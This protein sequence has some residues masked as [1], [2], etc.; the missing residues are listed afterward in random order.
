MWGLVHRSWS[1]RTARSWATPCASCP[2]SARCAWP[3]HRLIL[4]AARNTVFADLLAPA[5]A[6]VF[7]EVLSPTTLG[8]EPARLAAHLRGL[9]P[10]SAVLDTRSN[11]KAVNSWLAA[12]AVGA[13]I[14]SAN[15]GRH[16]LRRGISGFYQRRPAANSERVH[17]MVELGHL[18]ASHGARLVTVSA[19]PNFP[20]WLPA[21]P[22]WRSLRAEDLGGE[23]MG[24]IPAEAALAAVAELLEGLG[25]DELRADRA[26]PAD[27]RKLGAE[28]ERA[29]PRAA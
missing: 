3:G 21:T 29:S 2:G 16:V 25:P 4:L 9:G 15:V 1:C 8:E 12:T 7:D 24:D 19:R 5:E 22:H 18:A 26:A 23:L 14:Y 13:P 28:P 20:R 27:L 11:L 17:R 6:G 10:V